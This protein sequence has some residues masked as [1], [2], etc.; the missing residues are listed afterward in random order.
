MREFTLL[1]AAALASA[2][3]LPVVVVLFVIGAA[4]LWIGEARGLIRLGGLNQDN[5]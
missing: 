1:P 5:W 3:L 4:T 2:I